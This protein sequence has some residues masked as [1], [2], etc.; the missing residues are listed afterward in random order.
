[1]MEDVKNVA[2]FQMKIKVVAATDNIV[3]KNVE[4]FSIRSS[5]GF[6]DKK[7]KQTSG[8]SF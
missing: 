2:L 7:I 4:A 3:L 8:T 5:A 1:M 6:K